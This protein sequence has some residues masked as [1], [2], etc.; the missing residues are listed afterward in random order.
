MIERFKG[1]VITYAESKVKS[2]DYYFVQMTIDNDGQLSYRDIEKKI[3]Q[4]GVIS[5]LDANFEM[6]EYQYLTLK[7][8]IT[9]ILSIVSRRMGS[10]IIFMIPKSI[11]SR[12]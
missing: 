4:D 3:P 5:V 6:R 7:R 9:R 8:D 2:K 11:S 10:S 12:N 1:C